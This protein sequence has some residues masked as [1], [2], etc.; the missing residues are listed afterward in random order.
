MSGGIGRCGDLSFPGVYVRVDDSEILQFIRRGAG[1]DSLLSEDGL[2]G[3]DSDHGAA[4][5]STEEEDHDDND[6]EVGKNKDFCFLSGRCNES[7]F[8]INSW[9]VTDAESCLRQ[10][11]AS[12]GCNYF[13]FRGDSEEEKKKKKE[14]EEEE[15]LC[16][17]FGDCI[18]LE[19]ENCKNC[20]SGKVTCVITDEDAPKQMAVAPSKNE[21]DNAVIA[22]IGG[23]ADLD[24]T[25]A[26][27]L[28]TERGSC[29]AGLRMPE[30]RTRM[31]AAEVVDGEY[32][33]ACGGITEGLVPEKSCFKVKQINISSGSSNHCG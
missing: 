28:V 8:F 15:G 2:R 3:G 14:D 17:G 22:L 32:I 23:Y 31:F 30:R 19:T 9:P 6:E 29:R 5:P 12:H 21:S 7:S 25:D 1:I 26:I 27:D 33:I 10:C 11:Q 18:E 20:V 24:A 13:T 4:N 16:L